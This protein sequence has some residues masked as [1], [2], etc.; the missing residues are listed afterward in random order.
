MAVVGVV[1]AVAVV[2]GGGGG[3]GGGGRRGKTKIELV[4]YRWCPQG[5]AKK[6][7]VMA[8]EHG[9]RHVSPRGVFCCIHK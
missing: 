5:T 8:A 2:G 1:V 6:P 9:A 4:A 7:R 3:S